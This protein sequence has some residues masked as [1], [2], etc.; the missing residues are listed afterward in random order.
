MQWVQ[1]N[2]LKRST[3][4]QIYDHTKPAV[5]A[6]PVIV[7]GVDVQS[8]AFLKTY[9]WRRIR[10]AALKQAN[11]RCECCGASPKT[12]ARLNVDHIKPRKLRPDLALDPYNL[13]VLC[14]DCNAGKG[15]RDQSDWR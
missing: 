15:N 4:R 13:Q 3:G 8:P 7:E 2:A 9:A 6:K 10:Y 14:D 1:W 11:G 5:K 12:G